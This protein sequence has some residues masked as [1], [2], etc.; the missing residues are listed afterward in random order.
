[1]SI[2]QHTSHFGTEKEN[3]ITLVICH[4]D[5]Y[6]V[7]KLQTVTPAPHHNCLHTSR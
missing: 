5:Q 2:K 7:S 6:S 3:I 1:M 4:T